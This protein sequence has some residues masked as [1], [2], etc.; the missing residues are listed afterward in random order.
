MTFKAPYQ[1][2]MEAVRKQLAKIFK[3][4][5]LAGEAETEE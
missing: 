4:D 3:V 2:D 5:P 1:K